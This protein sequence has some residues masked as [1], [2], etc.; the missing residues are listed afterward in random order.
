VAFCAWPI[1]EAHRRRVVAEQRTI[2]IA[3]ED[4]QRMELRCGFPV[5]PARLRALSQQ[6]AFL[7]IAA[8]RDGEGHSR[9]ALG[10][11]D[12]AGRV[13]V[14]RIA[15]DALGRCGDLFLAISPRTRAG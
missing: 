9:A 3:I 10:R 13:F 8:S 1:K 15:A 11:V 5:S 14:D 7:A 2:R 4:D 6:R 12:G